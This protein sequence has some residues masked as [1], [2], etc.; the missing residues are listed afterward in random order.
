MI[1]KVICVENSQPDQWDF[2]VDKGY[3]VTKSGIIDDRGY[4][5]TMFI[6]DYEELTTVEAWLKWANDTPPLKFKLLE[7]AIRRF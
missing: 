7:E 2:T 4:K 3:T 6:G 5:F 1:S